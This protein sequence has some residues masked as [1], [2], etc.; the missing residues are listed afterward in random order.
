MDIRDTLFGDLPLEQW[1]PTPTDADA[2]E[3]WLSF[4]AA[5]KALAR[6]EVSGAIAAWLRVITMPDLE[7]R[8]YLQAWSFLRRNGVTPPADQAGRVLAVILEIP[9]KNGLDLLAAYR[10][11]TARYYNYSG[12][13]VIWE[14]PDNSLDAIV[15]TLMSAGEKVVRAI[16]VGDKPRP[17]APLPGQA[18]LNFLTLAGLAFGQAPLAA[19][20]ADPT[21][22]PVVVAGAVLMQK[23]IASVDQPHVKS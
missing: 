2:Q 13:S 14:H 23:L 6:G 19:L 1:P 10:D 16:G 12:A 20:M 9:V 8:H 18:R 11:C 21:A 5:R 7:S 15:N 17:P 3:P 22:K 4:I